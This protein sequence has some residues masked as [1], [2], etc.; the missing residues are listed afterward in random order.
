MKVAGVS[1]EDQLLPDLPKEIASLRSRSIRRSTSRSRRRDLPKRRLVK[2][3]ER[4]GIGRPCTYASIIQ[5]IQD[6]EYV[7]QHGSPILGDHAR[8]G[9]DRQADPGLPRHHECP[10]HR[11]DGT[12]S[13]TRSRKITSTG[14][15]CCKI[16]TARSMRSSM[17]RSE[18]IEHAG[19]SPS[20]YKCPKCGKPML[21]RISKNGFFLACSDR[22]CDDDAAGRSAGQADDPRSHANTSARSAAAR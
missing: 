19:G 14:S 1:S 20:P 4:L 16:S 6:R 15:S 12:A 10:V 13:S 11:R 22:E 9:R 17:A 3:L 8:Q 7:M 2:E 5:T 18:K 21:Y